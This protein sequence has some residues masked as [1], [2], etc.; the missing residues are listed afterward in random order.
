[1]TGTGA[2]L[3]VGEGDLLALVLGGEVGS[4]VPVRFSRS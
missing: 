3:G 4:R 2:G 1:M